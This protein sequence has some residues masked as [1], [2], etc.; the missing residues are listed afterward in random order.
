[1]SF[2]P[3]LPD[4]PQS[5]WRAEQPPR[6]VLSGPSRA[7][8]VVVGA[9]IAGLST[10]LLLARRG[11]SVIVL[12]AHRV[13]DGVTGSTTAKVSVLQGTRYSTIRQRH[14]V[15]TLEAYAHAQV[16]GREQLR[17]WVEELAPDCRLQEARGLTATTEAVH[18][19][20]V[21][22]EYEAARS[23]GLD[24]EWHGQGA[25]IGL[26]FVTEAAVSLD[27]QFHIDPWPYLQ[28]LANAV[29]R[30][31]GVVYERTR[32]MGLSGLRGS[33]VATEQGNVDADHVVVTTGLPLFDRAAWFTKAY[34]SRSYAVAVRL[35]DPDATPT[36][37]Y[38]G[39]DTPTWSLRPAVDPRDG[40]T[41]LVVGGGGHFPGRDPSPIAYQKRLVAWAA[42]RFDVTDVPYRWSAQDYRCA[43][44]L[45][46]VGPMWRLPTN[47]SVATGFAKWGMTNA[48]AAA[49]A[50]SDGIT[51]ERPAW[52]EPFDSRRLDV[53]AIKPFLSANAEVG[54]HLVKD[55]LT[56]G[57]S[58]T[59]EEVGRI[60]EG[61]A[62]V[63]RRG[64][65]RVGISRVDG[66]CRAV[67]AVC[68]HL[69]GV[70]AWND[71]ERSWDCPL[72]G[73]RFTADG[74]MLQ[75]PACRDLAPREAPT[76]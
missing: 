19:P 18:V 67:R 27:G 21:A 39:T 24:V 6:P 1:V 51:G 32:V 62:V 42:N 54:V 68:T 70:L 49:L 20:E 23:A 4:D 71:A 50:L 64:A 72:H 48:T 74:T 73:S 38:Y 9:G 57:P 47:V 15:E 52:A 56:G 3:E 7:D 75:G 26:P 30:S 12:D 5:V 31:G 16:L 34:P 60:E 29:E 43:D 41:L 28:A 45:P 53:G 46:A 10:A 40:S 65:D 2:R 35:A 76:S 36:D 13:G 25:D 59:G 17:A 8:V 58:G 66:T 55:W 33:G 44:E 14:G 63:V 61:Q 69:Q 22:E 37:G 11:L